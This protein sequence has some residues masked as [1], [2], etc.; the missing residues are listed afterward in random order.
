M[1]DRCDDNTGLLF[2]A[3]GLRIITGRLFS[4]DYIQH[5]CMAG[6]G[7]INAL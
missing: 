2:A 5:S 6:R 1:W 7:K 3:R 4:A